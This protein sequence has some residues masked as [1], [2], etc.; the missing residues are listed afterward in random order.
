M[1]NSKTLIVYYSRT[2]NTKALAELIQYVLHI[3]INYSRINALKLFKEINM[4]IQK[5]LLVG[6]FIELPPAINTSGTREYCEY[7]CSLLLVD[8]TF[9]FTEIKLGSIPQGIKL[10]DIS[11]LF[12]LELFSNIRTWFTLPN[13]VPF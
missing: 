9:Y 6:R 13:I 3:L 12:Q 1:E 10:L 5:K 7:Q 4:S 8:Q 11:L 2:G